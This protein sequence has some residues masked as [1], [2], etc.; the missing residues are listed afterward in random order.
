MNNEFQGTISGAGYGYVYVMSYPG[1]DKVKIGHSLNPT[2]RAADIGGTLA[3]ETPVVEA[4]FWCSERREAVE[5]MAHQIEAANRGNG[6]WFSISIGRA[7]EVIKSAAGQ[8]GVS[9]QLVFDR[10]EWEAK[11][12]AAAAAEVE[13]KAKARAKAEQEARAMAA[14]RAAK[15]AAESIERFRLAEEYAA[16]VAEAKAKKGK[17][18]ARLFI[19]AIIAILFGCALAVAFPIEMTNKANGFVT[20]LHLTL[21]LFVSFTTG[22]GAWFW[23]MAPEKYAKMIAN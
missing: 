23:D 9:A 14:E 12:A 7:V 11:A 13:R 19:A 8:V 10:N 15:A 17:L 16:T 6:E 3:P 1:S 5:R 21:G 2:T 4:Y 18:V 20:A 22:I